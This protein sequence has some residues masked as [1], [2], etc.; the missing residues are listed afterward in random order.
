MQFLECLILSGVVIELIAIRS[1]LIKLHDL[2]DFLHL[3]LVKLL[4][5]SVECG[6]S[7]SPILGLSL[8]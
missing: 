7:L 3:R 6:S 1:L 8:G 2:D 5:E 4:E